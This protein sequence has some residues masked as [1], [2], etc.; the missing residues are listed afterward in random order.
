[1]FESSFAI[2]FNASLPESVFSP[3]IPMFQLCFCSLLNKLWINLSRMHKIFKFIA[4]HLK[5]L[6]ICFYTVKK[7]ILLV[8]KSNA[9]KAGKYYKYF[10]ERVSVENSWMNH[11]WEKLSLI[12]KAQLHIFLIFLLEYLKV[13]FLLHYCST[14][15]YIPTPKSCEF[16]L[17]TQHWS[18][19]RN[20]KIST[21]SKILKRA[22]QRL[23][24]SIATGK[25]KS[26]VA[27]PN[28]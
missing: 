22:L 24:N 3:L 28:S 15:L 25:S 19:K 18:V 13:Q 12:T 14:F 8:E 16:T 4:N 23:T 27:K 6:F 5:K 10:F 2:F 1:M 9:E 26:I 17:M 7:I 20:G 21:L 11:A